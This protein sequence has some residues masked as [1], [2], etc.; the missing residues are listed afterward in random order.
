[1]GRRRLLVPL[2]L[3]RLEN[4]AGAQPPP[5]LASYGCWNKP[6]GQ[7]PD[8]SLMGLKR[9]CQQGWLQGESTFCL[10]RPPETSTFLA[11]QPFLRPESRPRRVLSL[12][13]PLLSSHPLPDS[14]P[15]R[16]NLQLP[17]TKTPNLGMSAKSS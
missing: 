1:M 16:G 12:P 2:S 5:G 7:K 15:L 11:L 17:P 13:P 8:A 14:D 6:T 9:P 4:V 3:Q 10:L